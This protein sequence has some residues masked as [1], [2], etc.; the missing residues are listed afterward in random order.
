MMVRQTDIAFLRLFY[1]YIKGF[2][3]SGSRTRKTL[4]LYTILARRKAANGDDQHF[5]TAKKGSCMTHY[6]ILCSRQP[7]DVL[8]RSPLLQRHPVLLPV[9]FL[10]GSVV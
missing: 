10:S 5:W 4:G 6:N 7:M 9:L 3:F 1:G 8:H 2:C